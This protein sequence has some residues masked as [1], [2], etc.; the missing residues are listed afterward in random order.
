MVPWLEGLGCQGFMP[1]LK[2]G[3]VGRVGRVGR[4]LGDSR[5]HYGTENFP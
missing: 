2:P 5:A 1:A 3:R 4:F